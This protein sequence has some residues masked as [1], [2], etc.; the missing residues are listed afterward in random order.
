MWTDPIV[1][2]YGLAC[3]AEQAFAV[4]TRRIGEWWLPEYSPNA[5][6]LE[7][8]TIE[9]DVGGRVLFSHRVEGDIVWGHVTDWQPPR[10]LVHTSVLAQPGDHPSQITVGFT[11]EGEGCRFSFAHGG[12]NDANAA[13]RDK[14]SEWRLILDRFAV[15][16]Q[17]APG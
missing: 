14:F 15:L 8:V 12:W 3:S 7:T 11:P 9:P 4:Y 2:E 10:R 6:T 16:A 17:Q 1:H 13:A 5:E